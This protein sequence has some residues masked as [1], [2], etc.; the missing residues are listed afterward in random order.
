[1]ANQWFRLYSEFATDPKIQMMDEA[2]QR[3]FIMLLCIRCSNG[4][5][6]LHET[7]TDVSVTFQ[8]RISPEEWLKTKQLFIQ[9]GLIDE[10]NR[11]LNWDKRQFVSDSSRDRVARH[12]ANKK[13]AISGERSET[14]TEFGAVETPS[15]ADVT[16]QKRPQIQIQNIKTNPPPPLSAVA[17][18]I[19]F[20]EFWETWPASTRKVGKA[21]CAKKWKA[22]K[23]DAI[24]SKIVKHVAAMKKTE[25]WR[26]FAPAPL[27]YLN[28]S[29]WEDE[30][31]PEKAVVQRPEIK[32]GEELA[33]SVGLAPSPERLTPSGREHARRLKALADATLRGKYH[34]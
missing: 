5:V 9:K 8:L 19:G 26:E 24:G 16:L 30:I 22:R 28:Q 6:T 32:S 25:Q 29:R 27:T 18:G 10:E 21:A 17:D 7:Y 4:D 13:K 23:L 34:S 20:A 2:M 12:R 33:R 31:P 11:V 15:N 3:R 14:D 1:M